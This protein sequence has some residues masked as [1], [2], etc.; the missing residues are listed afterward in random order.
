MFRRHR[1]NFNIK[2]KLAVSFFSAGL[3][4]CLVGCSSLSSHKCYCP[5]GK[6]EIDAYQAR[7]I[8]AIND[9]DLWRS[10]GEP[11]WCWGEVYSVEQVPTK[12]RFDKEGVIG[13]RYIPT[14]AD[15]V[16]RAIGVLVSV[17][18]LSRSVNVFFDL[19]TGKVIRIFAP[20]FLN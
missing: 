3:S 8:H 18:G 15:G 20:C 9:V 6:S 13:W 2:T 16:P 10:K 14:P 17:E 12:I 19:N 11:Y 5:L 7:A 1:L 4:L